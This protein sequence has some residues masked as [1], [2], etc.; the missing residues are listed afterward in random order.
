MRRPLTS[1]DR[2]VAHNNREAAGA[3]AV[4]ARLAVL[5]EQTEALLPAANRAATSVASLT[6]Q[7][8]QTARELEKARFRPG[9]FA[10]IMA[11]I[12]PA[13]TCTLS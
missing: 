13:T 3:V 9:P 10:R 1:I 8:S 6:A 7:A 2:M 12:V 5:T 4:A 11:L